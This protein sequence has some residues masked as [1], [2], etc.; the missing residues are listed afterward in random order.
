MKPDETIDYGVMIFRGR[1]DMREAAA[2]ARVQNASQALRNGDDEAALQL[3][4]EAVAIDSALP[5]SG[6]VLGDVLA[7]HGPQG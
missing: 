3:A 4:H 7:R 5:S 2:T 1:F 6:M